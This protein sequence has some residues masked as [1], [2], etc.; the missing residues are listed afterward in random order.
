MMLIGGRVS[1]HV[2]E[3]LY[4]EAE[5]KIGTLDSLCVLHES[6]EKW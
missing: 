2:Y 1:E 4:R 6:S 3:L 5:M